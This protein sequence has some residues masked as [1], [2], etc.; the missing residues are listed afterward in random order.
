VLAIIVHCSAEDNG[1]VVG[2]YVYIRSRHRGVAVDPLLNFLL[3]SCSGEP[4]RWRRLGVRRHPSP[5]RLSLVKKGVLAMYS[6]VGRGL[7]RESRGYKYKK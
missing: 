5:G 4:L 3:H 2:S 6:R 7:L 1:A